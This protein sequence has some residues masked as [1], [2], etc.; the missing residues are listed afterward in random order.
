MNDLSPSVTSGIL[1]S[2]YEAPLSVY[3]AGES[4]AN[5]RVTDKCH[6][7]LPVRYQERILFVRPMSREHRTA[8]EELDCDETKTKQDQKIVENYA[9]E[10]GEE[11]TIFDEPSL[12][13]TLEERLQWLPD[14]TDKNRQAREQS[15]EEK[16]KSTADCM[17]DE[18]KEI[19]EAAGEII[20]KSSSTL[21]KELEDI[22]LHWR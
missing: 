8:S 14:T 5:H 22:A 19:I 15:A 20:G 11:K 6:P 16:E 13:Y 10:R 17:P 1:V 4:F 7:D 21:A 9:R 3:L 18:A 2:N 12:T